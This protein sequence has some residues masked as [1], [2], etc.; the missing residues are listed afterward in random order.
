MTSEKCSFF[1]NGWLAKNEPPYKLEVGSWCPWSS[2]V[3]C[4]L[5]AM[6]SEPLQSKEMMLPGAIEHAHKLKSSLS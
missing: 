5:R 6:A 4:A 2:H 3:K 1:Y